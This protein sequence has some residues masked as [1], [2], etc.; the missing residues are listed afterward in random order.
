[1]QF[2][3]KNERNISKIYIKSRNRKQQKDELLYYKGENINKELTF[4]ELSK[5]CNKIEVIVV[6]N[7]SNEKKSHLVKSKDVI[8]SK[9]V[10]WAFIR[11]KDYKIEISKCKNGHIVNNILIKEF[12][13]TQYIDLS[14][15]KCGECKT[16]NKSISDNNEFYICFNCKKLMPLM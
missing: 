2:K 1:M 3:L 15:I 9:C 10:V 5:N 14:K 11:I 12:K 16:N 6:K 4:T 8:C 7:N 13:D